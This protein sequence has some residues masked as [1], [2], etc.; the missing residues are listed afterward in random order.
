M[1]A[2]AMTKDA[3]RRVREGNFIENSRTVLI[4]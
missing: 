4:G 1:L 2:K 3:P